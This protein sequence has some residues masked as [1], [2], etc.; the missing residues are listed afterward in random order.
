MALF[1]EVKMKQKLSVLHETQVSLSYSKQLDL[2]PIL[3]QLAP[4]QIFF[5]DR[6]LNKD[7]FIKKVL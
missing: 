6:V 7:L 4:V 3:S 1:E 5:W 2:P